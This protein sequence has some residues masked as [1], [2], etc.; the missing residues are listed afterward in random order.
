MSG[1]KTLQE[2]ISETKIYLKSGEYDLALDVLLSAIKVFPNEIPLIIN[3]GNI[4]KHKG[5]SDQA[6]SYY[7]KS[8]EIEKTKE[9][10]NNLS[11]IYLDNNNVDLAIDN[12]E[13]ALE[14]DP[15]YTDA[16][17]NAALAFER[18]GQYENAIDHI[19]VVLDLDK[20]NLRA[21]VILFNLYQNTCNWDEIGVIEKKLDTMA[22]NGLEHPFMGVSRTEDLEINYKIARSY[23]EKNYTQLGASSE[24]SM[25][26]GGIETS[27]SDMDKIKIGYIC[28]EFRNHPTYH[29]TKNL[30]KS[31]DSSKF[32]IFLFS[33]HHD[34]EIKKELKKDVFKFQDI[35]NISD[36]AAIEM[37][38]ECDLDILID[39]SVVIS[40]N[41]I[42][43][44]RAKPAKKIISY[45]GFPG[46]SGHDFY[47]YI[48]T[49]KIVTP[50]DYQSYFTEKFL[51]IP[52]CYQVNNGK[53]NFSSPMTSREEH[54][55]PQEATVLACFNQAFK[56]DKQTFECWI[57]I[58][59]EIPKSVLWLLN[60]NKLARNNLLK[61]IN[62]KN[63]S[64]TR[65]I[66]ADKVPREK[67]LERLKLA[68]VALDTRVYNGHTT[69]T[70]ALQV[71]VPV[72]TKTGNHFASRVS[73]SLLYSLDLDELC[74]DDMESYKNK[75]IEICK[76]EQIKS[77]ILNKLK[78]TN[79]YDTRHD[80]KVFAKKLEKTLLEIL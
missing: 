65:I 6:E 23:A 58:L 8:L 1:H 25:I 39:L 15:E 54:L 2:F 38:K 67:H 78:D 34:E 27:N 56:L 12:S 5:R 64:D 71:G 79:K 33:F 48:L 14:I 40:G 50:H 37:I 49:D 41:R 75:I 9:A 45:L 10:Y 66:F 55:L 60:D 17:C 22:G 47:D 43:I 77:K 4:L 62:E 53:S 11:V 59:Q 52:G 46:T 29:L 42:N 26:G 63:I 31:H 32:N 76:D 21:L 51:Y 7:K 24:F 13:K 19:K 20:K 36:A 70:D 80:N 73:T 69:T 28:G 68:D 18:D 16:R 72:V 61:Y 74:C 44:L 35:T 30:F 57:E 3:I